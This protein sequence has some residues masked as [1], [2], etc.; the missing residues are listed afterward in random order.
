MRMAK[1]DGQLWQS[2][3]LSHTHIYTHT[4]NT[5][6]ASSHTKIALC[7]SAS[8]SLPSQWMML[9]VITHPVFSMATTI[10]WVRWPFAKRFTMAPAPA[11]TTTIP[12][13]ARIATRIA[14]AMGYPS[15]RHSPKHIAAS[16][17]CLLHLC[18][19]SLC[20]SCNWTRRCQP[21]W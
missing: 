13:T 18:P 5:Y 20:W 8:S 19:V 21:K 9:P 16:N 15:R 6:L 4:Q 10:G 11:T 17:M 7:F 3:L 12:R 1:G 2:T 14:V